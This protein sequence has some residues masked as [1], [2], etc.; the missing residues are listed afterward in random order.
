MAEEGEYSSITKTFS[1]FASLSDACNVLPSLCVTDEKEYGIKNVLLHC[2]DIAMFNK[3]VRRCDV[4]VDVEECSVFIPDLWSMHLQVT[5]LQVDGGYNKKM[6]KYLT[7]KIATTVNEL[8]TN[9]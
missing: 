8:K 4:L 7:R 5:C 2:N 9:K 1:L 6:A 3:W